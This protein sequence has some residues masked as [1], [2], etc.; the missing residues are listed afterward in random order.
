MLRV[1]SGQ[2]RLASLTGKIKDFA[3]DPSVSLNTLH[4]WV[5]KA[6]GLILGL[7][8]AI[9]IIG[10]SY[11]IL[12]PVIGIFSVSFM[13][14][15]DLFNPLV[16]LVP[17][18]FSIINMRNAARYL[19]YF[20]VLGRTISF[21]LAMSALHVAAASFIGYGFARYRFPGNQILFGLVIFTIVIP[22]QTYMVPLWMQFRFFGPTDTNLIGNYLS[23]I[24]LT[25]TGVGLRSGLF[26][27]IY[28]QF[29]KGLPT[30]ISEAALIDGAGPI[31]TFLTVMM[32]NSKPATITVLLF[33]L[34]WHYGDTF[35]SGMLLTGRRFL[36]V[37]LGGVMQQYMQ[38]SGAHADYIGAQIVFFAS[39]TL[40]IIPI[41]VIYVI[42]Q[43]HFI[44]G[45]ERSGI[46]G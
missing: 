40:V 23:M 37:A 32:P 25:G 43:R 33:A 22:V 36:N 2:P 38:G 13:S 39:V 34:V 4:K 15:E 18:N 8:M 5:G 11:T 10:I 9:I 12:A 7:A 1:K 27:Y 26:I 46:V 41:M 35:Y 24:I 44:E 45:I 29:F 21:S 42:L 20:S 17:D 30:E 28:R 6:R 19:N 14:R 31:R 3:K 16:F